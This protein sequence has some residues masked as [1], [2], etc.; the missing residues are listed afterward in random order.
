MAPK[1][2]NKNTV[3]NIDKVDVDLKFD[4]VDDRTWVN[5]DKFPQFND[6]YNNS[7]ENSSLSDS[8]E[9]QFRV[10]ATIRYN[11]DGEITKEKTGFAFVKMTTVY[12]GTDGIKLFLKHQIME[13]VFIDGRIADMK[14][15]QWKSSVCTSIVKM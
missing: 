14:Y 13:S 7:Q 15:Y 3:K 12:G 1:S 11:L 6:D 4:E 9:V 2:S 10:K 8:S 5:K